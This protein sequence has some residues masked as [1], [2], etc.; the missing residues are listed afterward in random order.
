MKFNTEVTD[1]DNKKL[2]IEIENLT[3]AQAKAV[4]EL[5]AVWQFINDK[6]FF[7]WTAFCIDG[8]VD[9]NI[10]IKVNG[11]N[12]ERFMEDI[13]DRSGK[14]KIVQ[15]DGSLADEEMYFLDYMKIQHK[16]NEKKEADSGSES[17]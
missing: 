5:M 8:F 17:N 13:G 14:I 9:W 4:E 3:E 15:S 10:K 6:K 7:Y 1:P 12:P 11:N 16:L 2:T